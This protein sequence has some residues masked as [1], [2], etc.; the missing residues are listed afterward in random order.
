MS[1]DHSDRIRLNRGRALQFHARRNTRI[2]SRLG[3]ICILPTPLW[4]GEQ[5][6]QES[7]LLREHEEHRLQQPGMVTVLAQSDAE[8]D[9]IEAENAVLKTVSGWYGFLAARVRRNRI[10]SFLALRT[11]FR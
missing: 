8:F 6:V 2:T 11:G 5:L 7:F 3:T 9:C 4:I 1:T 10:L